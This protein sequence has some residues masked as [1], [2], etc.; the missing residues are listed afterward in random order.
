MNP[1][2]AL[3]PHFRRAGLV[4]TI[5]SLGAIGFATLLPEPPSDM[6]SIFCL[7][8]GSVGGVSAILNV[9]LFVP[10]GIGLALSGIRG[11]RALLAMCALSALIETAQFFVIPGRDA[12]IGDVLTNTLGGALGF[13]VA[14][15]ASTLLRPPA[16]TALALA[17]GWSAAWL[18][19]QAIS[20]FGFSPAMP[21]SE[22]Y[23]QLA[24]RLG[25]TEQFRGIVL[26]A[27]IA[28]VT[29]SDTRFPNSPSVR[30]LL[31]HGAS[32]TTTV[33]PDGVT[34]DIAPI[35][36]VA[37]AD[38]REIVLLA[39][40]ATKLVFG[41]RT[42]AAALRLRPLV[43]ALPGAFSAIPTGGSLGADTLVLRSR[44][45]ARE[46]WLSAWRGRIYDHHIPIFAS[47]GWTMLLPFQWFIEG[48]PREFLASAIWIA[49]LLFPL[50]YWGLLVLRYFQAQHSAR[51]G[52][53]AVPTALL[54]VYV[55]LVA[56]PQ[57][58][59]MAGAPLRDWLAALAGIVSGALASGAIATPDVLP[60]SSHIPAAQER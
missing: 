5:A 60:T 17:L 51:M 10:L 41:V 9:F 52:I 43:F 50:G 1:G 55:G 47:L 23:G 27:S 25:N 13:A 16:R 22:Y 8:C 38:E 7:V 36:R 18:A 19:I 29:V 42:G 48:R 45:S 40:N 56:V 33:V 24:R 26:R 30:A 4:L 59:G 20:A 14:R 53:I 37:D 31:L 6:G 58:F 15:Y 12:T 3:A 34:R 54:L 46:V 21:N 57:A 2:V 35:V 44:Y 49:C 28:D 32:V 11:N 39:Q